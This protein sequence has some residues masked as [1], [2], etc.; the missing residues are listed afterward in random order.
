MILF[1]DFDGVLHSDEVRI[2][3]F[4]RS[5][6]FLETLSLTDE[7]R[8]YLTADGRGVHGR[9][10]FEHAGRLFEIIAP[11]P[12]LKI[13]ISSSWREY[14][15]H[16]K[17]LTFLPPLLAERVIGQ[18]PQ[19]DSY[20]GVGS[21]LLEVLAYLDGNG[22]A[23]EPWIALDDQAQLFWDDTENPP[24]NLLIFKGAKAFTEDMAVALNERLA[25]IKTSPAD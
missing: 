22:V 10:L 6:E 12:S 15:D 19:C 25:K 4:R 16:D 9:N 7:Q 20:G 18:T 5:K 1:L 3:P 14:F 21:R 17:L 24:D 2:D 23:D 8:R 13:V 11:F